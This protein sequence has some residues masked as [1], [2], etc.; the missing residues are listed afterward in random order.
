MWIS[1]CGVSWDIS[2]FGILDERGAIR[3]IGDNPLTG[4]RLKGAKQVFM[5]TV[6]NAASF[7]SRWE[8]CRV[9]ITTIY[10]LL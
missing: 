7:A 4:A 9:L 10:M 3:G 1:S 6:K 5:I 8:G 2:Y